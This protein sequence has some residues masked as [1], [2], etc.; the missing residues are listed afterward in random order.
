MLW[1]A[2]IDSVEQF[3][4]QKDVDFVR[5]IETNIR[6]GIGSSQDQRDVALSTLDLAREEAGLQ[7]K[8]DWLVALGKWDEALLATKRELAEGE[9][10]LFTVVSNQVSN[11]IFVP[12]FAKTALYVE[13][14]DDLSFCPTGLC[15]SSRSCG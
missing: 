11:S 12:R 13:I 15:R 10:D 1:Y 7:P 14:A 5:L 2:E 6:V 4:A 9:R 8:S 3:K